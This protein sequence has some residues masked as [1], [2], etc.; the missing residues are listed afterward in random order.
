[1]KYFFIAS[2]FLFLTSCSTR[3]VTE[4]TIKNQN[5]YPISVTVQTNNCKQIFSGVKAHGEYKGEYDWTTIE[6]KEGQWIFKVKND[7]NGQTDTFTHGY[8]TD[9]ELNSFADLESKGSELKVRISE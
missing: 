5:E 8:F 7:M 3:K 4:V 2:T 9:G 6:R 1:M